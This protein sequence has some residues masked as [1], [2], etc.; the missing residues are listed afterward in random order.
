MAKFLT[1]H[2]DSAVKWM[3][4]LPDIG[5]RGL[6]DAASQHQRQVGSLRP[7]FYSEE[8]FVCAPEAYCGLSSLKLEN[9]SFDPDHGKGVN[10]L[11]FHRFSLR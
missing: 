7:Y 5:G 6:V 2:P 10:Y 11:K 4:L 8:S 9:R 1:L 3:N